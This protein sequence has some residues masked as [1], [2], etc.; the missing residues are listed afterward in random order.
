MA[1]FQE[2][3]DAAFHVNTDA[4]QI[5]WLLPA[6]REPNPLAVNLTIADVRA[7]VTT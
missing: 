2:A 5:Q 7:E 4:Q 6:D 3:G 1:A